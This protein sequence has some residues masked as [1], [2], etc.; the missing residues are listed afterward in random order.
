MVPKSTRDHSKMLLRVRAGLQ[1]HD[2]M[3]PLSNFFLIHRCYLPRN[4]DE[5]DPLKGSNILPLWIAF[6]SLVTSETEKK[7]LKVMSQCE[8]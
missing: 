5:I 6:V 7:V 4:R 8:S 2:F 1:K 3:G